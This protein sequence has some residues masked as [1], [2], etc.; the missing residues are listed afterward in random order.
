[1]EKPANLLIEETQKAHH[2]V[3]NFSLEHLQDKLEYLNVKSHFFENQTLII[4][5]II[6]K[7]ELK[8]KELLKEEQGLT[9]KLAEKTEEKKNLVKIL[10]G[11]KSQQKGKTHKKKEETLIRIN[12]FYH[13]PECLYKTKWDRIN[14]KR[15]IN[16]VHRQL[17][18]WKCSD[19]TKGK[20]IK[21]YFL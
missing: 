13:C 3:P 4:N 10:K 8:N 16:A 19:C 12:G 21:T 6:N 11:L 1:M 15:H 7:V 17:K 14:L 18:P 20:R 2:E 9:D 5:E